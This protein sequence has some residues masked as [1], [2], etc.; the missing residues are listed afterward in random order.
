VV[1]RFGELGGDHRCRIV[2]C[3][4]DNDNDN[5]NDN[6]EDKDSGELDVS[7]IAEGAACTAAR[8]AEVTPDC[9]F[10]RNAFGLRWPNCYDSDV[11]I[12]GNCGTGPRE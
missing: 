11:K 2:D 7:A 5:D 8:F 9:A 1:G 12:V 10:S 6:D 3:D 4:K